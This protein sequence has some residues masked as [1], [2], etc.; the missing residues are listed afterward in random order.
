MVEFIAGD[1]AVGERVEAGLGLQDVE[2]E[3]DAL[4]LTPLFFDHSFYCRACDGMASEKTCPH[5]AGERVTL[6]GTRVRELL[7]VGESLPL[8]FSRP[9]V[10]AI[11]I[12]AARAPAAAGGARP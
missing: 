9:E 3:P 4:G 5:T 12:E 7:A 8:E 10:A 2:F 1:G 11:L 6:S